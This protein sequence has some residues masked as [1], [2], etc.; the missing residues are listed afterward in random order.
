MNL[1]RLARALSLEMLGF[2]VVMLATVS[3]FGMTIHQLLEFYQKAP[4]IAQ[5]LREQP[6]EAAKSLTGVRPLPQERRFYCIVDTNCPKP[7]TESKI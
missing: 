2:G 4:V 5:A 6:A 1:P 3:A 7:K